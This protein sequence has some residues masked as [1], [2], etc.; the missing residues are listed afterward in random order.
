MKRRIKCIKTKPYSKEYYLHQ[1]LARL[2]Q[3]LDE[4]PD[5]AAVRN[6]RRKPAPLNLV[7]MV[8]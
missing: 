4:I 1:Q 2:V 7:E 8:F 5:L 3:S 6:T